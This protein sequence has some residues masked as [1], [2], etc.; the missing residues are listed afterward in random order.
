MLIRKVLFIFLLLFL[1][2]FFCGFSLFFGCVC[3]MI[4]REFVFG[5]MDGDLVDVCH[6]VVVLVVKMKF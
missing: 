3:K 1:L 2:L 4:D 6:D 5:I